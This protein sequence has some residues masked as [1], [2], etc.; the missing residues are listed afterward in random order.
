M[1]DKFKALFWKYP[2]ALIDAHIESDTGKC[3]ID[4]WQDPSLPQPDEAELERT[5][6][7][8]D[9]FITQKTVQDK[10]DKKNRKRAFMQKLG[11]NKSDLQG[12]FELIEDRHED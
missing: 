5:F 12:L 11:L 9:V 4:K 2:T 1:V 10:Q 3:V 6:Q 7:E 8:Y